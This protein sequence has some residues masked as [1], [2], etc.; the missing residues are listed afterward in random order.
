MTAQTIQEGLIAYLEAQISTAGK[1]YPIQVPQDGP[2]PA[3][4]YQVIDDDQML[5]HGGGTNYCKARIQID[6]MAKE[7]VNLSAY[8]VAQGLAGL[9]RKKLDGYKGLMGTVQ[10]EYCKTSLSDDWADLHQ[11]PIASFDVTIH[12]ILQ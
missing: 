8:A 6:L 7:T 3:W 11:L 9:M 2:Y 12:Y 5:S 10:V 4:A 1:S